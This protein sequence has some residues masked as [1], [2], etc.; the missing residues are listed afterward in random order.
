MNIFTFVIFFVLRKKIDFILNI[1]K[2]MG[3]GISAEC[4][5]LRLFKN[6]KWFYYT[7]VSIKEEKKWIV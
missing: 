7:S 6:R 3:D 5:R 2:E 4:W 1:L